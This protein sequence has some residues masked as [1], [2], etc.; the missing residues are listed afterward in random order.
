MSLFRK[1]PIVVGINDMVEVMGGGREGGVRVVG[2]CY[3]AKCRHAIC[4]RDRLHLGAWINDRCWSKNST[5]CFCET[6]SMSKYLYQLRTVSG[7]LYKRLPIITWHPRVGL[8]FEALHSKEWSISNF[9]CSLTRNIISHR[10]CAQ[11]SILIRC[12]LIQMKY[13]YTTNPRCITYSFLSE[14]L[15]ECAVEFGS[16]RVKIPVA[17]WAAVAV[18][19][20]FQWSASWFQIR[21]CTQT[22]RLKLT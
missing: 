16:E 10:R 15:R 21:K 12:E 6:D 14:R 11:I 9:P 4:H 18:G 17:V 19:G 13:D 1:V 8:L 2:W 22:M 3:G 20:A 7:A 5:P